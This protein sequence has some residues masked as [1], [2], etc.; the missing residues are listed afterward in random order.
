MGLM[1]VLFINTHRDGDTPLNDLRAGIR[2]TRKTAWR[3]ALLPN[4]AIS[5]HGE[6]YKP[7]T[8]YIF[9]SADF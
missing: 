5:G 4:Y 2:T 7:P 6:L 1:A 8:L 9:L 3:I